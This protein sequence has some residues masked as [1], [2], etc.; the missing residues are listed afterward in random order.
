VA[1]LLRWLRPRIHS[2]HVWLNAPVVTSLSCS[3]FL[4]AAI[5]ATLLAI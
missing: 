4:W 1:A 2:A 5:I 3:G